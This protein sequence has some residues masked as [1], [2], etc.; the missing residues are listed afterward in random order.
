MENNQSSAG[1]LGLFWAT[2]NHAYWREQRR[3]CG[4][5][6]KNLLHGHKGGRGKCPRAGCPRTSLHSS[7]HYMNC[8]QKTRTQRW[9]QSLIS[10]NAKPKKW[11]HKMKHSLS[12]TTRRAAAKPWH[13]VCVPNSS[14]WPLWCR[15]LYIIMAF[16]SY[17]KRGASGEISTS[18]LLSIG[19]QEGFLSR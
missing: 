1:G 5:E 3:G 2:I 6:R 14:L 10:L 19:G 7:P 16:E 15:C 9:E 4:T 17:G 13:L 11:R 8:S 12:R 18:S